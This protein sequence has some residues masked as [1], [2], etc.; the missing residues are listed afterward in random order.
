[1]TLNSKKVIHT[2]RIGITLLCIILL[3]SVRLRA[4]ELE[5]SNSTFEIQGMEVPD[6]V[7]DIVLY[8][9]NVWSNYITT[10][11]PIRISVSQQELQ[12]N[13]NAYAKPTNYYAINGIYYPCALAEKILGKNL[14]GSNADIEVVINKNIN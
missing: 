2:Y 11:T 1:M 9:A 4:Q 10:T 7:M 3:S 12:S 14:N 8:S 6:S 5:N 13:V